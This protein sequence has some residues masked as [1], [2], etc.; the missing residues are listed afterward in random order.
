[1]MI[2]SFIA[3]LLVTC[4]FPINIH[5]IACTPDQLKGDFNSFRTTGGGGTYAPGSNQIV[6]YD[7]PTGSPV[8]GITGVIVVSSGGTP[9]SPFINSGIPAT[10]VVNGP[11]IGGSINLRLPTNLPAGSFVY[12][13]ALTTTTGSCTLDSIPF[14]STGSTVINQCSIGQSQCVSD[15][16]FQNCISTPN[17]NIFGG[18]LQI[19]GGATTCR[20]IGS[21]AVCSLGNPSTCT[22]G[23]FR[24]VGSGFQQCYQAAGGNTWTATLSCATGT[25]CQLQGNSIICSPSGIPSNQCI[26]NSRRCVSSSQYQICELGPLGNYIWSSSTLCPA[27]TICTGSGACTLSTPNDCTPGY[28]TCVSGTTWKSCSENIGGRWQYGSAFEC[29]P[30][31]TCSTYLTNYIIC[32]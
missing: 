28:M 27:P 13:L 20:Q 4:L 21:V 26:A 9:Y 1:M 3:V 17:G 25:K 10:F 2:F 30:G 22:L 18:A 15:K 23:S 24:C 16:T 7:H 29:A 32:S 6:S 14:T 12:R 31:T 19:C 8:T 5:G 11:D